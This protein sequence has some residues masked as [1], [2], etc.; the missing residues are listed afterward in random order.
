MKLNGF[1][2]FVV[3]LAAAHPGQV[4]EVIGSEM[5]AQL[6]VGSDHPHLMFLQD[7]AG[8]HPSVRRLLVPRLLA[9]LEAVETVAENV[10]AANWSHHLD[11]AWRIMD[12]VLLPDETAAARTLCATKARETKDWTL[13]LAWTKGLFLIDPEA[14]T[15]FLEE[16]LK[17]AGT[18]EV[19]E[20]FVVLFDDRTWLPAS[21]DSPTRA[22]VLVRLVRMAFHVIRNQ[23]DVARP[24]VGSTGSRGRR[25]MVRD[26]LFNLL[27]ETPGSEARLGLVELA[28]E[29]GFS[30]FPDRVR[31]L[32]RR[33]AAF[34]AEPGPLSPTAAWEI[35]TRFSVQPQDRDGL[36]ATMLHRLGDLAENVAHHDFTDR[37]TLRSIEVEEEMQRTLALR[38]EAISCG[39]YMVSREDEVADRKRTDIRLSLQ[40]G[41]RAAIEIKMAESWTV[42]D[43]EQALRDQLVGQYLR[44]P[45]CRAGCF[46]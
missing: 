2:G 39:A 16:A 20:A 40:T 37:A 9:A 46:C 41:I 5:T 31:F 15:G 30:A 10:A 8:A 26:R 22:R 1:A 27:V 33:R 34:D 44:Y 43:L 35:E 12:G 36:M 17:F 23:D 7:I 24:S 11:H 32:A 3:A 13:R 19:A 25:E 4:D 42:T 45:T 14:A 21:V 28:D 18:D 29:A 6:A 38:L